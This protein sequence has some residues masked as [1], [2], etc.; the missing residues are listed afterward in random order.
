VARLRFLGADSLFSFLS[1]A[2]LTT[3]K[4]SG[5]KTSLGLGG[6]FVNVV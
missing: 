4:L 3:K 6:S 5:G 1:G 2:C